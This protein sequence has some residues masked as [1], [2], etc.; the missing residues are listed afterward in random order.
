MMNTTTDAP[1][2]VIGENRD[3]GLFSAVIVAIFL[4]SAWYAVRAC[5]SMDSGMSMP[6][7]WTMSMAW[8]KM[9]GQTWPEAFGS[10]MSMWIVMMVAMMLPCL[11]PMLA[12]CRLRA[13]CVQP[14]FAAMG[15]F[16]IWA[17]AGVAV[18]VPGIFLALAQMHSD[19]VSHVTPFASAIVVLLSGIAQF[20]PWKRRALGRCRHSECAPSTNTVR[21]AFRFGLSMGADCVLCCGCL[22]AILIVTDIMNVW[23]MAAITVAINAERIS[24]RPILLARTAGAIITLAG[25]YLI[26]HA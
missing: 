5:L 17:I 16:A 2:R 19:A 23:I 6:G 20:T 12:A 10:F 11:A 15:Y 13:G 25:V 8:M 24:P 14:L 3:A 1:A 22:M 4:G 18:Y 26:A 21:G 9:P 7:G